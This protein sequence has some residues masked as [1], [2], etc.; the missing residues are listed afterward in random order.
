MKG[1]R[2]GKG[3][4]RLFAFFTTS[5]KYYLYTLLLLVLGPP[6]SSESTASIVQLVRMKS[7]ILRKVPGCSAPL[8]SLSGCNRGLA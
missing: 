3:N 5:T 7:E 8:N 1:E 2:V 4:G 6:K